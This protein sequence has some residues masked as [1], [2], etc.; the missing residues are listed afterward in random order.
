MRR[1]LKWMVR[2][3]LLRSRWRRRICSSGSCCGRYTPFPRWSRSTSTSGWTRAGATGRTRRCA[4]L[5]L[6]RAGHLDAAGRIGRCS[7]L[8]LVREPRAAAVAGTLRRAGAHAHATASSSTRNRAEPIPTSFP[9][10]S[11]AI[12]IRASARTCSTSPARPATR[13]RSISPRTGKTTRDPHRR[14][15]GHA[16]LHRHVARQ[17]RAHACWRRSSAPPSIPGSS[18]ASPRRCWAP[19]TRDAKP[20][21]KTAMCATI[22][23]MLA[24]GQNNPLRKLYPGARGLRPHR[25]ARPHRQHRFRRSPLRG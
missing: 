10:A 14:R 17:L 1:L 16:R 7:A 12:S 2:L 13:A 24:S 15:P 8:R 9:S 20:A 25:C 11:R 5:L 6:H 22:K 21:L 19:A 3:L 18:T 4:A 23:A